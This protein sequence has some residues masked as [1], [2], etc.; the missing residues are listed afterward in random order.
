MMN[1]PFPDKKYEIILVDPPWKYA[2]SADAGK[3]GASHKYD[4]MT[5]E[6]ICNMPVKNIM[7]ENCIVFMWVTNPFLQDCFKVADAWGLTY[8][9]K[10]FNWVKYTV[11]G[12]LFFGMGR[13]TRANSEDCLLFVK[14]K[15]KRADAS[16]PQIVRSRILNHSVKPPEVR[17]SIVKLMG[18]LPRIELFARQKKEGWES[19][20]NQL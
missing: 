17:N 7:A 1:T 5:L 11:N 10:A 4:V 3:R 13:W 6:D 16:V 8:K 14:G 12:K 19:W 15:P 20:G 18:D 9:T 2:D